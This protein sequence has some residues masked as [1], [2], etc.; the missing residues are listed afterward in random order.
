MGRASFFVLVFGGAIRSEGVLR[1]MARRPHVTDDEP[2]SGIESELLALAH[3]AAHA[4]LEPSPSGAAPAAQRE[5]ARDWVLRRA[6]VAADVIGCA[7]AL[8]FVQLTFIDD[9][10]GSA[11]MV[12]LMAAGVA[13]WVVLAQVLGLYERRSSFGTRSTADDFPT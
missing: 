3:R 10:F 2:G 5:H 8:L 9:P 7:A 1:R 6:L 11:G 4:E 13:G 12:A